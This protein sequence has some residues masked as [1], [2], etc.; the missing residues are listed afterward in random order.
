[1]YKLKPIS[2]RVTKMRAKYRDTRPEICT[3]RYRLIT[4]FYTGHPELEGMLRRARAFHYICE[5]IPVRID[6]GEVIV[7]AQS[8]KYRACA[9]YPENSVSWLKEEL[10]S[11]FIS[12]RDIDP[13]IVSDEDRAFILSTID[14]WMGECMSAKT[15]AQIVDEYFDH[16]GNGVVTFRGEGQAQAPVGHFCA[17][18]ETVLKRGLVSVRREAEEKMA[19]IVDEGFPGDSIDRYNFYRAVSLVCDGMILLAKRHA[20]LA[21]EMAET[22]KDPSRKSELSAMADTLGR[23]MEGPARSFP[24]ALQS[25]YMYQTCM[26]LDANMHGIS[27]GRIDQ[28]LGDYYEADLKA[29]LITPAYAQ[30]LMDLFYL[31][32]AEMNKPWSYA[33]TMSNPGYTN[34]MLMTLGGVKKDG[35]DATNP[36]TYM[37]LQ[38][39]GRL[40]LHDPPQALRVHRGTPPELWEAAI[41][42]TKI[43]GGVPTFEND[44]VIIPALMSRGLPLE[45]ARNY[46]LI[47]C[48][49][50]A[51]CGD[52]WAS[53]GGTGTDS[54]MNLL[55][56]L[57]LAIND[58]HNPLN[59]PGE[60]GDGKERVREG[61]ATGYLYEMETFEQVL[62]AYKKQLDYFVKWQAA[63]I[64]SFEYIARETLP[65]PVVSATMDGCMEKGADVMHG[66][67]RYNSTG[68]SGVGVGNVADSLSMIKHLCFDTKKCTTRELYDALVSDWKG[69]EE[70]LSYIRNKAPHY[71]N[72]VAEQDSFAAW[73]ARIYSDAVNACTGPRG[74]YSAGLYPVTSN[75]WLGY[76]TAATPDGRR[77]G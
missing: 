18:Y 37:M 65:Q 47:G 70:L 46:C 20:A 50:P 9:L 1:M 33:A 41:E 38:S 52:E 59:E 55:N 5:N 19:R 75:V 71:G 60:R 72:G 3:A 10:E 4:E 7:G 34:G 64:N 61:P 30:E 56:A 42:T 2:L 66:G 43:A 15:D 39:S 67:A 8:A 73:T 58:G 29:G 57:W 24:D 69:Y 6:E 28:Y 77:A 17:N 49:E 53:P 14:Y 51:G 44:E 36:V 27:F 25:V 48:V 32:V 21:A 62:D 31:K 45:S 26:C 16:L 35:A 22:E 13:Y 74:R 68:M 11:G 23:C 40:V 54:F 12:T 76:I 63:N